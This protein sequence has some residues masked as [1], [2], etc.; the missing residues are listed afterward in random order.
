MDVG[1]VSERI[2]N[3][4]YHPVWRLLLAQVWVR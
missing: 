2:G 3:F 1:F 4:Q